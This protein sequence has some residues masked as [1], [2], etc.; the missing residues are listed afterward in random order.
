LSLILPVHKAV[1][2]N[3][4]VTEIGVPADVTY[5]EFSAFS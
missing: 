5:A 1:D 4:L 2:N 3:P